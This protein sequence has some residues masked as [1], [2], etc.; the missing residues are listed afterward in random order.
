M[1]SDT[2]FHF[3]LLVDERGLDGAALLAELASR[4]VFFAQDIGTRADDLAGRLALAQKCIDALSNLNDKTAAG[5]P[6]GEH[7]SDCAGA[8]ETAE[9][10]LHFSAGIWPSTDEINRRLEGVAELERQINEARKSENPLFR[11]ISALGECGLDHHWNPEGA[12]G[13][14]ESD[15]NKQ[16]IDG[17]AELFEMQL[18]L[19]Q[20]LALPVIV[21]S[22][23][24]FDGTI[25]CIK[26]CGYD[27]GIIHCYSYGKNEV[28]AFL[29]RGWYISFSGSVT[30]A[31]KS[32]IDEIHD[33]IKFVPDDRILLETDAP[34]LAPVPMRGQTNTPV[35]VE[36]TYRFAAAA[37]GVTPESLSGTVDANVRTLF[38]C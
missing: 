9:N 30:Y 15:F 24:A 25:S 21:H 17:E 34:Y 8:R 6:A 29:D 7:K 19:A 26:N 13:R 32:H 14:C 35:F 4:S 1:F 20:K 28:R 16:M 11:K 33:L 37:R 36:H 2:H 12:D 22:R 38:K 27:N 18:S 3:S 23:D 5:A 31:K 10:F